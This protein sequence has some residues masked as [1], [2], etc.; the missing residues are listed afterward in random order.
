MNRPT[1]DDST[2]EEHAIEITTQEITQV[3]FYKSR[4]E[5]ANLVYSL[6]IKH[7]GIAFISS[8]RNVKKKKINMFWNIQLKNNLTEMK[9]Y[10]N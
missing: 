8:V 1:L 7:W 5:T 3:H 4:S 10:V 6:Y 9:Y 2:E